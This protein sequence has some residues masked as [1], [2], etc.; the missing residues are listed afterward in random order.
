MNNYLK[1]RV[2]S[3]ATYLI[4]TKKTIREVASYFKVSKSTI[5]KDMN[6]RLKNV[7]QELY[8][9]VRFILDNHL[10]T[11]HIKGGYITKQKYLNQVS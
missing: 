9:S 2:I 3:E 5:H 11:R 1:E 4:K 10:S 8:K 6:D 7:S